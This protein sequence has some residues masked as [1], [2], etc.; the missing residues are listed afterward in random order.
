MAWVLD[1]A[2][3]APGMSV[4]DLGCGNGA[5]LREMRSR[6][7][8]AVGCDRSFGMLRSAAPHRDLVNADAAALALRTDSFDV[9]LAPHMLYHVPDRAEAAREL[10][11]VLKPGGVCVAV[12]NGAD[13]MRAMRVLVETAVR[14]GTPRWE[15]RSPARYAFSMENGEAQLAI[16]FESITSV[17]PRGVAPVT[18]TDAAV[19]A[20]YVAS[21]ADHYQDEVD[22]PW[23]DVVAEV[24]REVEDAIEA[25]GAF[26]VTGD[27]GA[28]VCR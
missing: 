18:V 1:L 9:V 28:F 4:L 14:R 15:M 23:A 12:T 20:D 17:R 13:H 8:E 21:V 5:Y 27:T 2:A 11:R 6:G 22:R 7:I 25:D 24:R 19:V 26:V 10:R 3:V 16:A